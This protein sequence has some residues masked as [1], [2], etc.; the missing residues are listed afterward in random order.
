MTT[1]IHRTGSRRLTDGLE[2]AAA[3]LLPE[4]ICRTFRV[5]PYASQDGEVLVAAADADDEITLQVVSERIDAPVVLVRHTAN[6]IV[7]A[8]DETY[9]PVEDELETVEERRTRVQ[10]AQM[11]TRSGLITNEQL[12]DAMLQHARSGDA[13]GEILVANSAISEDILVAALSEIHQMQ[14]VGLRDFTPD[15][16]VARRL[17][18]PIAQRH[19]V[20]PVADA[21]GTLLVAVQRPM[22]AELLEEVEE[23]V[24]QPVRQLLANRVDLDELIQ[25]VH[26]DHYSE[27]AT[28]F[29]MENAPEISAHK[30][31]STGQKVVGIGF[32]V[33]VAV[34]MV[35]SPM[36]TLIALVGLASAIYL[37][38]SVYKFRL[39]LRALGT[40]LEIEATPEEI[41]ALDERTLP[42]YTILVP[43]YKEGN[44]VKRLVRDM[45][46]LDYPRTRLDVKLLCEEDD[47]E[48]IDMI[49]SMELPPHFHC[50]VVPDSLPKTKPKACNFGL[51]VARG[52]YC[53][54][55]DAEDRPDPDQLKKAIIAFRQTADNVACVQGKLNHF[56]QDQNLLTAWFA[57]EYSMHFELVLPAMGAAEQPIPLGGTSNHFKTSILRELGAW[58]PFNVTED[59]DLGIRLHREGYRTAM[60]DSTTLE[61]ANSSVPNWIRQRSRWNKGYY[62]TWLVHMRNPIGLIAKIGLK[63]FISFNLTMGSAYVLLMNPIFWSL[64]TLFVFTQAS[65]IQALFPGLVF[66]VASAMLFVGNFVFIYL[67]LAGSLQRGEFGITRTAL[68]SPLYWGLM[69]WAAWKGFLQLF[70]NPFYWEK[71]EHG[72]DEEEV[73]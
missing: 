29:L 53:V 66:Y 68:L 38:V 10:M 20:L 1:S 26:G 27:L 15:M 37:V 23:A 11:L 72:L 46:A 6:E 24:Q 57:N 35:V 36:N 58:D 60:I 33:L 22:D 48:T 44:I 19:Q 18:E 51:Q 39:T 56:N 42:I 34:F 69:S 47:V 43:L 14:R 63:D 12:Q 73:H 7:A 70:T 25:K 5:M 55:F 61:E 65:F 59:A 28:S 54:I 4:G 67:N 21:D 49:K 31:F 71:T 52:K 2:S 40:H 41:A 62:Q 3:T 8:I 30:V 32:L 16:E 9:P 50:V 17:P 13:L 64:T 45:N